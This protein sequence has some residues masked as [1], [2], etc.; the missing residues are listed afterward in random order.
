MS[1]IQT[2]PLTFIPAE[3]ATGAATSNPPAISAGTV[4]TTSIA[5][6]VPSAVSTGVVSSL[7]AGDSALL[8]N[9]LDGVH[10]LNIASAALLIGLVIASLTCGVMCT[11][12]VTYLNGKNRGGALIIGMVVSMVLV[13]LVQ[14]VAMVAAGYSAMIV[15]FGN[16]ESWLNSRTT[17]TSQLAFV[18]LAASIAHTFFA[19]RL[20]AVKRSMTLTMTILLFTLLQFAFAIVAVAQMDQL[21]F[22]NVLLLG[23]DDI[24]AECATY[25]VQ[26]GINVTIAAVAYVWIQKP[27]VLQKYGRTTFMEEFQYW[28]IKSLFGA[29]CLAIFNA[30]QSAISDLEMLWLA[31]TFIIG[32]LYTLSVLLTLESDRPTGP[33]PTVISLARAPRSDSRSL[34]RR[35]SMATLTD[36]AALWEDIVKAQTIKAARL[37]LPKE[38][39]KTTYSPDYEK[40]ARLQA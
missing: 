35:S 31:G 5:S 4:F 38:V 1:T 18:G 27:Y 40:D 12:A 2:F 16:R 22:V 9:L 3:S 6:S 10:D 28:T 7:P 25:S 15:D 20:H 36:D 24:W 14:F 33:S 37:S 17:V 11:K 30:I 29:F 23:A 13:N 32:N 39:D 26:A 19:F 8:Q 34:A 21:G